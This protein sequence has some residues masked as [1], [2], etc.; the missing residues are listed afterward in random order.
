M[1]SVLYPLWDANLKVGHSVRTLAE[2]AEAGRDD[3]ATL[4]ALLSSR[5]IVGDAELHAELLGVVTRLVKG[6]PLASRLAELE[7]ARR[8]ETPYQIMAADLKQGRGALRTH[9][10]LWWERR[11]AELLGMPT[12]DP[13]PVEVDARHA[14]LRARNAVH[15]AARRANDRFVV[16]LREP[17]A[18]WL[19][20]DV[21]DLAAMIMSA[22]DAGDRIADRRWPDIHVETD[23]MVRFGRRI[24]GAV[25]SRFSQEEEMTDGGVFTLAVTAA[26]RIDGARFT[27]EEEATIRNADSASWTAA[28][29]RAFEMLLTAGARGRSIFGQLDDLGW[30]DEVFPE[31]RAVATAPQLAPFHD[32]PVGAHLHRTVAEMLALIEDP[33]TAPIAD[34]VGASEELILAA[35]LHDIGKARGG[36]H[37]ELGADLASA[38]L[39]RAGFGPATI[40]AVSEA[41]RLHLLLPETATRRD[42][43]DPVVIDEVADDVGTG[44]QLRILY[45]LAIAD[46]RATGTTVW[47]PWRASLLGSLYRSVL[48]AIE[49]EGAPSASEDVDAIVA[50]AEGTGVDR[51]AIEEHVAAM[52]E[53]YLDTTPPDDVLW[54]MS[55]ADTHPEDR[56]SI[57]VDPRD[58]GR[59]LVVGRDRIGFILAVSRAFSANGVGVLD[60]RLRTRSDGVALDTFDV[61]DDRTGDPVPDDRWE[62]VMAD[63]LVSLDEMADIR[64]RVRERIETY[65]RP[66][67]GASVSVRGR[68]DGR[69]VAIEVRMPDGVGV[70]TTIV[71]ALHTEGLDIHLARIDTMGN[72]ARDVFFVRRVG[73]IAFRTAAEIAALESRLVDRLSP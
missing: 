39:R 53:D 27:A 44:R 71:E 63:L 32:H 19:D 4:T 22:L 16:G 28:D 43:A 55:A 13:D 57:V 70:F 8:R 30:I 67:P 6:R 26:G 29:R 47:N 12:D 10:G 68:I 21:V 45:L 66:S 60:A 48:A 52:P 33:T 61:A 46:L 72:E 56:A 51:R 62:R 41:V 9:Q 31:W 40:G 3:F 11:R 69:Y 49:A 7:R 15:A 2:T 36:D 54:H 37:S 50:A 34:E 23:S 64:P 1:R 14:L 35:F 24:F 38:F 5:L 18:D 59:V 65:R 17:A 73:G 25:R 58:N 42:I 20:V